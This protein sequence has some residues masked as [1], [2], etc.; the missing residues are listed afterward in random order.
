MS[1]IPRFTRA[2]A[3]SMIAGAGCDLL[4]RAEAD[5]D[6]AGCT[7][8]RIT[9]T[10]VLQLDFTEAPALPDPASIVTLDANH[11]RFA[12]LASGSR[13]AFMVFDAD[14]RFLQT[15]GIGGDGPDEFGR[16]DDIVFDATDSLW[17]FDGG[18]AR[19]DVY[20]PDL[21][22]VRS[23]PLDGPLHGVIALDDGTLAI[24]GGGATLEGLPYRA[25]LLHRDGTIEPFAPAGSD[26]ALGEQGVIG[27]AGPA[28]VWLTA[29]HEYAVERWSTRST[30]QSVITRAPAWFTPPDPVL[31][32][33]YAEVTDARPAILDVIEDAA[34]RL[35]VIAGVLDAK[36]PDPTTAS[37]RTDVNIDEYFDTII[38]IVDADSA[39]LVTSARFDFSPPAFLRDGLFYRFVIDMMGTPGIEITRI[40]MQ[41][42]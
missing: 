2:L 6:P 15:V 9:V 11:E 21:V 37:G 31:I 1:A 22:R 32:S 3:L 34:G 24:F 35:W 36:A 29:L 33:K 23:V 38:E 14:G 7:T 27:A 16:I 4:K 18:N 10:P 19:A 25:R 39:T 17:V 40:T 26:R 12:V 5:L 28:A 30:R 13:T 8:C 42:F 41:E 20:G